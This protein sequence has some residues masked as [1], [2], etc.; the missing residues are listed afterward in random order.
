MEDALPPQARRQ[1]GNAATSDAAFEVITP[2]PAPA[3]TSRYPKYQARISGPILNR[4]DIHI[5]VPRLRHDEL[6][7]T[8]QGEASA[9]VRARERQLARFTGAP[10]TSNAQMRPRDIRH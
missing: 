4:L 7:S 3:A 8:R 2:A 1:K 10:V 5:E 6:L 9:S